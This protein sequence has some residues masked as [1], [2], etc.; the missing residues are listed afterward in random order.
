MSKTAEEG[1]LSS[2]DEIEASKL[3]VKEMLDFDARLSPV[4]F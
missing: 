4:M 2:P 3:A 1:E